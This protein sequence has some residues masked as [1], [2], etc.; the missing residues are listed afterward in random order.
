MT[1][2]SKSSAMLVHAK[3]SL[4]FRNKSCDEVTWYVDEILFMMS[5]AFSKTNYMQIVLDDLVI[6]CMNQNVFISI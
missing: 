4:V 1:G 5:I 6:F 3:C 2:K